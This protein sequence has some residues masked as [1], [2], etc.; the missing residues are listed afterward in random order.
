VVEESNPGAK[1]D[2][3]DVDMDLVEQAGI[4]TLLDGVGPVGWSLRWDRSRWG[5]RRTLLSSMHRT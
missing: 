5:S 4:Q 1:K 3:R 2:G